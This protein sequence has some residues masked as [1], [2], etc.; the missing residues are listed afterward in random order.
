LPPR[1]SEQE[2]MLEGELP[3]LPFFRAPPQPLHPMTSYF[4]AW[5]F[6]GYKVSLKSSFLKSLRALRTP[7]SYFPLRSF[8]FHWC[9]NYESFGCACALGRR[10]PNT[11]PSPRILLFSNSPGF[12]RFSLLSCQGSRNRTYFDDLDL[13]TFLDFSLSSNSHEFFS[14]LWIL[15]RN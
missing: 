3:E 14:R 12:D 8:R 2:R 11:R 6:E 10:P 4:L 7:Y 5:S 15:N 13:S 9:D 1:F